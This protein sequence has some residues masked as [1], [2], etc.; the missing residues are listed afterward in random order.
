MFRKHLFTARGLDACRRSG[1]PSEAGGDLSPVA[2]LP[3]IKTV[4]LAQARAGV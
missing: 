1:T 2:A 4:K 3:S